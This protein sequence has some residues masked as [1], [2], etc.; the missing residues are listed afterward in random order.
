MLNNFINFK[1]GLIIGNWKMNGSLLENY[2]FLEKIIKYLKKN[3]KVSKNFEVGILA[4]FPY[5]HQVSIIL[6]NI[7]G[8]NFGSQDISQHKFGAFTGE[9]S[10]S[11]IADFNCKWVL[12][13]HSERR[14]MHNE[15]N[16]VIINKIKSAL[17]F[18][19][20]PIIC[21]GENFSDYKKGNTL[22]VIFKQLKPIFSLDIEYLS[23]LILAYEPIWAIGTGKNPKPEII[24]NIHLSIKNKFNDF[25][26]KNIPLLYGG[27]VNEYN[28]VE[29]FKMNDIDGFLIGTSSLCVDKFCKI[30]SI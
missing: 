3:Y 23:R 26:V 9:V 13:G 6:N 20:L 28:A 16:K 2:N 27:S 4:P 17:S 24:Q 12:I 18:N 15:S 10:G 14:I 1:K 8:M 11:M 5:L 22:S 7:H 19:L 21:F 30:L 29:L 25:R